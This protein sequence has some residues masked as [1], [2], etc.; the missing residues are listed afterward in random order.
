MIKL[1]LSLALFF[2]ANSFASVCK[3]ESYNYLY[4][5]S[6]I[7]KNIIKNT[8]C[9]DERTQ[10]FLNYINLTSTKIVK[11]ETLYADFGIY[12]INH[13]ISVQNLTDII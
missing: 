6:A 4:R 3:I 9:N 13:E 12:V 10:Q 8:D 11:P 1:F 7:D 5:F 2:S